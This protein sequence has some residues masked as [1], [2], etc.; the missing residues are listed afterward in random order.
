MSIPGSWSEYL[1]SLREKEQRKIDELAQKDAHEISGKR[2][3][4][5]KITTKQN[6]E[7]EKMRAELAELQP[8]EAIKYANILFEIYKKGALYYLGMAEADFMQAPWDEVKAVVD[9]CAWRV[10]HGSAFL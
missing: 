9:A 10:I 8:V 4:R 6:Q 2:Y 7:L 1:K 3:T 5:L